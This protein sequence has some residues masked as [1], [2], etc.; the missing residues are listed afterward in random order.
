MA[1]GE[2][3]DQAQVYDPI[4]AH[5]HPADGAEQPLVDLP[6]LDRT[7]DSTTSYGYPSRISI[8][9]GQLSGDRVVAPP[10]SVAQV[11]YPA[12]GDQCIGQVAI[13]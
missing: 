8:S 2:E 7:L 6:D 5:D 9:A 1:T 10:A 3:G 12:A 4:L 13:F 11:A